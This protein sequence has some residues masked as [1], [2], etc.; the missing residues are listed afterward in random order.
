[1]TFDIYPII[2]S[3]VLCQC[4]DY[5]LQRDSPRGI[6]EPLNDAAQ[7]QQQQQ[8]RWQRPVGFKCHTAWLTVVSKCIHCTFFSTLCVHVCICI[9]TLY[10]ACFLC[11]CCILPVRPTFVDGWLYRMTSGSIDL[12]FIHDRNS[13]ELFHDYV[14]HT[15]TRTHARTYQCIRFYNTI[16]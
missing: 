10:I 4:F 5:Y 6:W 16:D 9:R 12:V 15:H 8:Q 1:M 3:Y 13:M 7:R 14:E 11:I 2:Y